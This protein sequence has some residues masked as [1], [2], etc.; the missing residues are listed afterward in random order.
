[1][2]TYTLRNICNR[3]LQ[4]TVQSLLWVKTSV[5]EDS[6]RMQNLQKRHSFFDKFGYQVELS[7]Y[8]VN[9]FS[10]DIVHGV[11]HGFVVQW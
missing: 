6:C 8:F 4:I 1:M 3:Q 11:L 7:R 2:L 9:S 5:P 10:S